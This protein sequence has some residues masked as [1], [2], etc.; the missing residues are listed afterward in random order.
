MLVPENATDLLRYLLDNF[1]KTLQPQTEFKNSPLDW[2]AYYDPDNSHIIRYPSD[3]VITDSAKGR[4]TSIS[5]TTSGGG[6]HMR[7]SASQYQRR[8]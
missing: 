1:V 7:R 2:D 4:P 3:W 8:R 5:S 6:V